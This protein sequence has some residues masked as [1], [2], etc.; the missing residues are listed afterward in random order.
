MDWMAYP[1]DL[2]V[3]VQTKREFRPVIDKLGG[4][5]ILFSQ[6][7]AGNAGETAMISFSDVVKVHQDF[8]GDPDSVTHS[9]RMLRMEGGDGAHAGRH[10]AGAADARKAAS[11]AAADH[12]H[13]CGKRDRGSNAKLPEVDGPGSASERGCLLDYVVAVP[14]AVHGEN[15]VAEDLKTRG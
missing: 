6:L 1:I 11:R 5:G 15:K 3:A 7:L 9:M 4:T 2:V 13:D 8:T 10:A 14:A 12:P